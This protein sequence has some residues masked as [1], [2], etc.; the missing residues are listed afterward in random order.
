MLNFLRW[1]RCRILRR[2]GQVLAQIE[3]SDD[4]DYRVVYRC[5][6]CRDVLGWE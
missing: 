6:R 1:N 3:L 2:H 4:A 5:A